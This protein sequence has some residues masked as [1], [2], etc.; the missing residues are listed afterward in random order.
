MLA[1]T[2]SFLLRTVPPVVCALFLAR[3]SLNGGE[4]EDIAGTDTSAGGGDTGAETDTDNDTDTDT[5]AHTDADADI[6]ADADAGTATSIGIPG[7]AVET[8]S[9]AALFAGLVSACASDGGVSGTVPVPLR[10]TGF[11]VGAA[12]KASLLALPEYAEV[13]SREFNY[14]TAVNDMKWESTEPEPGVFTFEAADQVAAFASEHD[15][16]VKGHT[17]VWHNQ[18]PAWMSELQGESAVRNALTQHIETV[19]GHFRDEYPGR[20][21]A[22]DVVNEA[23]IGPGDPVT[24]RDSVFYRELGE[25]YVAEAFH[26]ARQVDPDLQLIYND[27]GIEDMGPKSNAAFEWIREMVNAGVPVDGV[28]FQMHTGVL[29]GP[30]GE[31]FAENLA[32]YTELGLTVN[33]SEM[34]VSLCQ[35]YETREEALLAQRVRYNDLVSACVQNPRCDAVTFWGFT[36]AHTWLDRF[37]PCDGDDFKPW[38]LL[39]NESY[40]RKP[41]WWGVYDALTGCIQETSD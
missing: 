25:G 40:S 21:V 38:P 18:L 17:L 10:E 5:D 29:P 19:V 1:I 11:R 2:D 33:I 6:D 12:L 32:R 20:V 9:D 16:L 3:C 37:G 31:E 4:G 13:A 36:D 14:V 34:D 26:L 24:L 28:G 27:Y 22:W 30:Q 23:V 15:M 8:D 39:F 41:A 35:G 7:T